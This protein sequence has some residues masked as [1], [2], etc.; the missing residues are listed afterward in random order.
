MASSGN[1]FRWVNKAATNGVPVG[2]VTRDCLPG[3]NCNYVIRANGFVGNYEAGNDYA[4]FEDWGRKTSAN[5]EY[6]VANEDVA[7]M[8]I[9]LSIIYSTIAYCEI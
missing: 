2:A 1:V 7:G 3:R 6:L 4:E 5:W 8:G 9:I